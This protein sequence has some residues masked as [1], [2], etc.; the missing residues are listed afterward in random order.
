VLDLQVVTRS[1]VRGQR[2]RWQGAAGLETYDPTSTI[3]P[4]SRPSRQV[5]ATWPYN[6]LTLLL[7]R[8]RQ[9]PGHRD[10]RPT[11]QPNDSGGRAATRFRGSS[12]LVP[13]SITGVRDGLSLLQTNTLQACRMR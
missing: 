9:T 8:R 5:R 6:G 2:S 4:E 11:M 13:Y 7:V 1:V 10:G 12:L 3:A